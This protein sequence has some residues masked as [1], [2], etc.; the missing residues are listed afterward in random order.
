MDGKHSFEKGMDAHLHAQLDAQTASPKRHIPP[1]LMPFK[2]PKMPLFCGF[3]T[4]YSTILAR[5][6]AL[7]VFDCAW[8]MVDLQFQN[9]NISSFRVLNTSALPGLFLMGSAVRQGFL[10]CL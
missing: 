7:E 5:I 8:F 4:P 2:H 6:S 1:P 10:L 9:H 3:D